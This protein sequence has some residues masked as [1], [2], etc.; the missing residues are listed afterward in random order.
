LGIALSC[1][2]TGQSKTRINI[3]F[4]IFHQ[5]VIVGGTRSAMRGLMAYHFRSFVPVVL[6]LLMVGGSL[7][8]DQVPPS[9]VKN[10]QPA[11]PTSGVVPPKSSAS[12]G[13]GTAPGVPPVPVEVATVVDGVDCRPGDL[14]G[15]LARDAKTAVAIICQEVRETH[16]KVPEFAGVFKINIRPLGSSLIVSIVHEDLSG[17]VIAERRTSIGSISSI[18]R[19]A[20]G[21]VSKLQRHGGKKDGDPNFNSYYPNDSQRR[22]H[23][24][25]FDLALV[26]MVL[27][28][29]GVYAA[30]GGMLGVSHELGAYTLLGNLRVAFGKNINNRT[31]YVSV[32]TGVR[33]SLLSGNTRPFVGLGAMWS[34][35]ELESFDPDTNKVFDGFNHGIA[36]YVELGVQALR[37]SPSH[38]SLALRV[39]LPLWDVETKDRQSRWVV[40]VTL[41]LG[42]NF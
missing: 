41:A 16:R 36:P 17:K 19:V 31:N 37:D 11:V 4:L 30:A 13:A 29:N 10:T 2:H 27:P 21:L 39:D 25:H 40:P 26:A 1:F 12:A 3:Q 6:G 7:W 9:D 38:V 22:H 28:N 15:L 24:T 34:R 23:S 20:P 32:A 35:L 18:E 5:A 14:E 33:R 8:A 42:Y